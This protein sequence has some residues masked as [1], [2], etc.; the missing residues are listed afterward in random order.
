MEAIRFDGLLRALAAS[1]SRR[2]IW[3]YAVTLSLIHPISLHEVA[4]GRKRRNKKRRRRRPPT[5]PAPPPSATCAANCTGKTCG[6]DGCGGTCGTCAEAATCENGQCLCPPPN[7]CGTDCC[8]GPPSCFEE[9]CTCIGDDTNYCSCPPDAKLCGSGVGCCLAE[10]SCVSP[11]DCFD[12]GPICA[13][14]TQICSASNDVCQFEFAFCGSGPLGSCG[15]FTHA[16]D[17]PLCAVMTA[18]DQSHCPESNECAEDGDC[19]AGEV[20]ANVGCC[21][22]GVLPFVGR[23]VVPCP[24]P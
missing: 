3:R 13:C 8:D 19:V 1:E 14:S 21:N 18:P 12:S 15:C 22:P 2:G 16:S 23:C 6:G 5:L 20:C 10:D 9:H 24:T 4:A 17:T 11:L 7:Q